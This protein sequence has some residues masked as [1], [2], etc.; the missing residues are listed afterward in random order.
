[1]NE[2]ELMAAV[3]SYVAMHTMQGQAEQA[4]SAGQ[5]S[6]MK[7]TLAAVFGMLLPLLTQIGHHH[8]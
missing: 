1:M 3:P 2:R 8:H 4:E 6:G 5:K 7:D